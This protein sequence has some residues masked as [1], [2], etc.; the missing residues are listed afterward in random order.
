[1]IKVFPHQATPETVWE[2][3]GENL[4]ALRRHGLKLP[5][6]D[7][8]LATIAIELDVELWTRDNHFTMMQTVMPKLKLYQEPA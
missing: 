4:A 8:L 7:V 2:P 5:Y 1:M 6:P 3:L